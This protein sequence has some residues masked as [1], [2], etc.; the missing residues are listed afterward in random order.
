A[1]IRA[2][3]GPALARNQRF[4]QRLAHVPL[5]G[6]PVWVDD[7]HF[8]LDYHLRHTALP[9][10]GDERQLK[11]LA[12]RL[13]SQKLDLHKPLWELWFVE[14]LE[15]DR[16]AVV[17]KVHHCMVDGIAGVD[18]MGMLMRLVPETGAGSD[19]APPRW[20]PRPAPGPARLLGDELARRAA[21]PLSLLRAGGRALSRPREG[22]D[23][24]R[25]AVEAVSEILSP[26]LK[27]ATPTPLNH[28]VGPHR[29]FDWTEL[30]LDAVKEV[31][32]RLGGTVNDVV[33]AVVA[34]AMR[35]FLARRGVAVDELDFRAQVPVNVRAPRERGRLGNRVAT[36]VARLPVHEPDPRRRY[37]EVL[38]TTRALK[39]SKQVRG[40]ELL[41]TLGDW[42]AKELLAGIVRMTSQG[43]AFNMTVTNVPGPNVPA[44]LLDSQ[45]Q[46]IYPVVPL[47]SNQCLGIALFSYDG[48]LFWG[49]HACWDSVPDL[50]DLVGGVQAEF[51]ALR[52]LE[53]EAAP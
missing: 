38:R 10:P 42:T 52:A 4:R 17:T 48:R 15:G 47:F 40:S 32:N 34:G 25:E 24:A 36:L 12:G 28:P 13:L 16:C 27:T 41:E 11:R 5:I 9:L 31:K 22:I 39:G 14:G 21:L 50:H 2:L 26:G 20:L 35:S 7:E 51:A 46:A 44:Y 3:A 18:L 30:D 6:H 1:R 49:F 23:G 45:M 19:E 43:L 37:Q 53:P 29:R 8:Q 33:L